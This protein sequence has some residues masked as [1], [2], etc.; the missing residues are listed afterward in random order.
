MHGELG[1]ETVR[2]AQRVGDVRVLAAS[3]PVGLTAAL[4]LAR[5]LGPYLVGGDIVRGRLRGALDHA[6]GA[7]QPVHLRLVD[8]GGLVALDDAD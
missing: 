5:Q 8:V 7:G 6:R 4:H 1:W 2:T 3:G